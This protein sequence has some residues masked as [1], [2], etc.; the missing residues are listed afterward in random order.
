MLTDNCP[1]ILFHLWSF[2]KNPGDLV[3]FQLAQEIYKN[4]DGT[5]RPTLV[6]GYTRKFFESSRDY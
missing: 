2:N 6:F 1:Q 5:L 4:L 3:Q